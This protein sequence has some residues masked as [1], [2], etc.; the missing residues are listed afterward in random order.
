MRLITSLLIPLFLM[1][2]TYSYAEEE[3][4]CKECRGKI[5]TGPTYVNIDVLQDGKT[6]RSLDLFAWKA[7]A[8]VRIYSGL[9]VK[10]SAFVGGGD[11]RFYS[12]GGA[13]GF[14]FPVFDWLTLFPNIGYTGGKFHS[15]VDLPIDVETPMGNM[16][17][18]IDNVNEHIRS[19]GPLIGLDASFKIDE[20]WRLCLIFQYAWSNVRTHFTKHKDGI[21][22]VYKTHTEG[23]NYAAILEHDI[24]EHWSLSFGV[25]YNLTLSKDKE[26]LRAKGAKAGL[27]YWF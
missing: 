20:T 6:I 12:L 1:I 27:V 16:Q 23:P 7:D 17:L 9:A 19:N 8:F 3:T 11:A 2:S 26:G 14:C 15:K 22:A 25:G 10:G 18:V 13:I 24:A 21:D 4:D 5:D